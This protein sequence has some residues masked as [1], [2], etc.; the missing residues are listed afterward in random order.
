MA[1]ITKMLNVYKKYNAPDSKSRLGNLPCPMG[2]NNL[3]LGTKLLIFG[4]D[5]RSRR[6]PNIGD[7]YGKYYSSIFTI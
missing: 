6:C 7:S 1:K 3:N 5:I 2:H 4:G